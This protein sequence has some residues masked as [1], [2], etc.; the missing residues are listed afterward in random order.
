MVY[1]TSY[2][3]L[4]DSPKPSYTWTKLTLM[5][6]MIARWVNDPKNLGNMLICNFYASVSLHINT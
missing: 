4:T 6:H 3:L 1:H 5:T 2:H